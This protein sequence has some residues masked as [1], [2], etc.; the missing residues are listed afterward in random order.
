M[1]TDWKKLRKIFENKSA[2]KALI[3][4]QSYHG[5]AIRLSLKEK[6]SIELA[7][8]RNPEFQWI[9]SES[10]LKHF[11]QCEVNCKLPG[12]EQ[13]SDQD[14]MCRITLIPQKVGK[15]SITLHYLNPEKPTHVAKVFRLDYE[16][17]NR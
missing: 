17:Q 11:S 14:K 10:S 13:V 15:G 8:K 12:Y 9:P 4:D 1:K 16:I 6:I 2:P 7:S 5:K 3:L